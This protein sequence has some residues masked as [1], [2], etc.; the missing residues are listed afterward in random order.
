MP[1][2]ADFMAGIDGKA[3][4]RAWQRHLGGLPQ[5]AAQ[6][7]QD[8]L[9]ALPEEAWRAL[10]AST[11]CQI[12]QRN[13]LR[14]WP[15]AQDRFNE[16]RAFIYLQT[17]GCT[18]IAFAPISMA[19]RGPDLIAERAGWAIT[20]EVKTIHLKAGSAHI[21]RK[22]TSRLQDAKA[23]ASIVEA[24]EAYIYLVATGSD[25]A[26]IRKAIDMSALSPCRLVVDCG[27]AV[28][29]FS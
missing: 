23:Q 24:G 15:Q 18:G 7:W 25:I 17:I 28:E 13:P 2:I 19:T 4:R 21:A 5:D 10:K 12:D 9:S 11:L 8:L 16:A 27:D 3:K 6:Y 1:R 20:C 22:L 14:A 29:V 26:T